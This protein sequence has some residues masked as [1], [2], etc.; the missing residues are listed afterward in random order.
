MRHPEP[1]P[2]AA[3]G[4]MQDPHDYHPLPVLAQH[5]PRIAETVQ[6]LWGAPELDAYL[7]R[8]LI[9]KRGTRVGFPPE[10]VKALLTLSRQH[11]EQFKF[12]TLDDIWTTDPKATKG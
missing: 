12:R 4:N 3:M 2:A 11:I 8:L 9:D 10:V 6:T 1:P 7:D 5:F